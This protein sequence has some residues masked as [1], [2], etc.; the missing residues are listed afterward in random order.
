LRRQ[1]LD[2]FIDNTKQLAAADLTENVRRRR[3]IEPQLAC[4]KAPLTDLRLAGDSHSAGVQ[5]AAEG[6]PTVQTCRL[7][8]QRQKGRLHGIV[9]I[10]FRDQKAAAHRPHQRRMAMH[11]LG[12]RFRVTPLRPAAEQLEIGFRLQAK[13]AALPDQLTQRGSMHERRP[14]QEKMSLPVTSANERNG[15]GDFAR[16][17][18]STHRYLAPSIPSSIDR[19]PSIA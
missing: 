7:S 5:P 2:L 19:S 11:K 15:L 14:N 18:L 13:P 3:M 1:A 16:I 6:R 17:Y 9:A 10:G 4:P 8:R 12:K